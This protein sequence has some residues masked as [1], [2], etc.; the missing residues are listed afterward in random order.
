MITVKVE[1]VTL[2]EKA[3]KRPFATDVQ[4][5]MNMEIGFNVQ[6]RV[7]DHIAM[8]SVTRHKS[9]DRLGAPHSGFLE[10]A[11][12][13]IKSESKHVNADG[14]RGLIESENATVDSVDIV[15]CNTPGMS[16]AFHSL[17]ITPKKAKALT[18]PINAVSYAKSAKDLRQQ[19][20]KMH[21][22]GRV[23][24]G[25]RGGS[26][27]TLALYVLCGKV[28]IP[29]DRGLLPMEQEI[30]DWAADTADSFLSLEFAREGLQVQ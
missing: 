6:E 13:R 3:L 10:F 19:G 15:I 12:G 23:L 28:T 2:L 7:A 9:A 30:A 11:P 24:K 26:D 16:R 20:W 18:I 17:V 4:R 5:R 22:E 1:G 8:A 27:E 25:S 14:S 21:R 29:Q